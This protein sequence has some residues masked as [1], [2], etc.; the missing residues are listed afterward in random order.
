MVILQF[1]I[2]VAIIVGT[3]IVSRQVSFLVNMDPG[4]E[5]RNMIVVDRIYPLGNSIEKFCEGVRGIPGV[6]NASNSTTYLGFSNHTATFSVRG[7]ER[8]SSFMFDLNFVDPEFMETYGL[9]IWNNTG[10]FF[11]NTEP[12]DTM[13]VIINEAAVDHYQFKDPLGT[14][15]QSPDIE[16][17]MVDYR[18][19]GVVNDFHHSSLRKAIS[20]YLFA[21]KT[22]SQLPS[23][24]ISIRF[25]NRNKYSQE[26]IK[27]VHQLWNEMTDNEPFQY[28]Y[29]DAELDKY[30]R[31]ELRT[32]KVSMLFS[33]LAIIIACLGLLG[34]TIFNTERRFREIAIRKA[35][36][37]SL[38]DLLMII[39]REILVLLGIS[40]VLAWTI[41]YFF[42]KNWLQVFP[43][44]IGFTPG[45]Y[46][47]AALVALVIAMIAVNV[48]TLKAA[49]S[50]PVDALYHE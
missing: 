39:S 50:N 36:G 19:I 32:G 10:R 34:L 48:I 6:V 29:L 40:I 7:V 33:I 22:T 35:L 18:V 9:S 11:S 44:N 2:S 25:E 43:Y 21:Y 28:F 14:I 31:E 30:Y 24:Y 47:V 45:I 17:N 23:G 16:G 4:F 26:T 41:A 46:L 3:L 42:M 8:S 1:T 27:K 20:P 37:A 12:D 38:Y 13:T 15:I 5:D 49:R